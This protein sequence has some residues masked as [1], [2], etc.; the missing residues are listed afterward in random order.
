MHL[1]TLL[2]L[3]GRALHANIAGQIKIRVSPA[4]SVFSASFLA[5]VDII[6]IISELQC[7]AFFQYIIHCLFTVL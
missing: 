2:P 3:G 6:I 4:E 5:W 7:I 1:A